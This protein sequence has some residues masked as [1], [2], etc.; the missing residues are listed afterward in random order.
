MFRAVVFLLA[1]TCC[2]G[3]DSAE[4]RSVASRAIKLRRGIDRVES[5]PGSP[6]KKA[7]SNPVPVG[8]AV[9]NGASRRR[10]RP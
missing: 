2:I 5:R 9:M 4:R 8:H 10:M 7:T 3:A 6:M 1:A